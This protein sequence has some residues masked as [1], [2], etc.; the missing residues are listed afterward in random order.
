M[1]APEP[2]SQEDE[3]PEADIAWLRLQAMDLNPGGIGA[4]RLLRIAAT[5]RALLRDK[6]RL[7]WLDS[8]DAEGYGLLS[9][10]AGRWALSST[11]MQDVPE[12]EPANIWTS[13]YVTKDDWKPKVR[14]AI[15]AAMAA[16][17]PSAPKEE[18]TD[19]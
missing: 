6:D 5:L 16:R 18:R 15:D 13:F 11:G 14:D 8:F 17:S 2:Y 19:G 1:T 12:E 3:T 10:D 9:D 7:D 4:S